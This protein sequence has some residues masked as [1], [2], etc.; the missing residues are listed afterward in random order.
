MTIATPDASCSK[1][2]PS[3]LTLYQGD[4]GLVHQAV[5]LI[6]ALDGLGICHLELVE[7]HSRLLQNHSSR[8]PCLP[9]LN[10]ISVEPHAPGS[11][12]NQF[13]KII[14]HLLYEFEMPVYP[15]SFNQ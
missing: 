11:C 13:Q 12:Y 6:T 2:A 7:Q 1:T 4:V 10:N 8:L 3:T 5:S 9:L 14:A 15:L